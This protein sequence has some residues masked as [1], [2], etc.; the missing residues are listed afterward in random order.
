[1][2]PPPRPSITH[3]AMHPPSAGTPHL[4]SRRPRPQPPLPVY[5]NEAQGGT[6]HVSLD[7]AKGSCRRSVRHRLVD[8]MRRLRPTSGSVADPQH[9][10]LRVRWPEG[11]RSGPKY[12]SSTDARLCSGRYDNGPCTT[13]PCKPL[14]I[15]P[16]GRRGSH[17]IWTRN[18]PRTVHR[19]DGS[20]RWLP[21]HG[22]PGIGPQGR[23]YQEG[24]PLL[25]RASREDPLSS[26]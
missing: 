25:L 8:M 22:G 11:T 15:G 7:A 18:T 2:L 4:E 9:H 3:A 26:T 10:S 13:G 20:T 14:R 21:A 6:L 16:A 23:R 12:P 1:M 5:P 24:P 19:H 17:V